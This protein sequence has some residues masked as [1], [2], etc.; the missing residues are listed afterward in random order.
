MDVDRGEQSGKQRDRLASD[1]NQLPTTFSSEHSLGTTR[2]LV[3]SAAVF[4][5]FFTSA[6][7]AR[8]A[9]PFLRPAED[10][11]GSLETTHPRYPQPRCRMEIRVYL[12]EMQIAAATPVFALARVD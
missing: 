11:S 5:F 6:T 2:I 12:H 4:D 7:Y 3:L 10:C 9:T 1:P 8:H